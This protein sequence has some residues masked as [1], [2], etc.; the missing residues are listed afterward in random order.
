MLPI[1]SVICQ[2]RYIIVAI[3]IILYTEFLKCAIPV[4]CLNYMVR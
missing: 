4:V 3:S 2:Q 1:R